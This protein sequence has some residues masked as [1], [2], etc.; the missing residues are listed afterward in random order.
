MRSLGTWAMV[1]ITAFPEVDPVCQNM[2]LFSAIFPFRLCIKCEGMEFFLFEQL[3][4]EFFLPREAYFLTLVLL[5]RTFSVLDR[6]AV[7]LGCDRHGEAGQGQGELP[8][9]QRWWSDEGNPHARW[10]QPGH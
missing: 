9:L 1:Q 5:F 3:F 10:G 4:S 2:A 7:P 6:P 8:R